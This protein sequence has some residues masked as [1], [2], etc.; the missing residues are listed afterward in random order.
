MELMELQERI[1]DL[2]KRSGRDR[3]VGANQLGSAVG[4]PGQGMQKRL[5]AMFT[6]VLPDYD[7]SR[8]LAM[9][10]GDR[11]LAGPESGYDVGISLPVA[12]DI[13]YL[14]IGAS[15]LP[16]NGED[17]QEDAEKIL[18][19][20]DKYLTRLDNIKPLKSI[21]QY[22][23]IDKYMSWQSSRTYFADSAP[24][25]IREMRFETWLYNKN[26]EFPS[27]GPSASSGAGIYNQPWNSMGELYAGLLSFPVG[28][29]GVMEVL[30]IFSESM[31]TMHFFAT[32]ESVVVESP[33]FFECERDQSLDGFMSPMTDMKGKCP[34]VHIVEKGYLI[35][36]LDTEYPAE[37]FAGYDKILPLHSMRYYLRR[38]AKWPLPG[39][40]IGLLAKPWPSHVWW[41]QDTS[42]L[43]Y[44]GNWFE[45]NYYTS[46]V[47]TAILE[48]PEGLSGPVYKCVVRGVEVCVASTDFYGYAVGERVAI[49][50]ISDLD[51]FMDQAKG[52]F[53]WKEMDNL[54]AR[55]KM[56][57]Q[58]PSILPYIVNTNMMIVPISFYNS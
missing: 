36:S 56:E 39:E 19:F 12:S 57:K 4:S 22:A 25:V 9:D 46:G 11:L 14:A 40:F 45:T 18:G 16:F 27:K 29:M 48:P 6:T 44:S 21:Q 50:R 26:T 33:D 51:R 5:R 54:I 41:F 15:I 55:E 3:T 30:S 2:V 47:V 34:G 37:P 17:Y 32:D 20:L 8:L 24:H 49:L 35:T 10:V 1:Q 58:T 7:F 31:D 52:N 23:D 13:W 53:K 42:P 43:L 38:D 28:P